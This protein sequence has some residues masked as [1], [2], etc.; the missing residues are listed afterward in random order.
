[1]RVSDLERSPVAGGKQRRL[2]VRS[3]VPD[4]TDRVDH[5]PRAQ[6][7]S[8]GKLRVAG[9]AAAERAALLEQPRAGCTM[10]RAVD[11]TASEQRLVRR[12]H[13]RIDIERRDVGDDRLQVRGHR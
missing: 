5:V 1:M 10:D 3:A 11:A 2:A 12:I 7:V 9:R 13:D 6:P 4:R 8:A